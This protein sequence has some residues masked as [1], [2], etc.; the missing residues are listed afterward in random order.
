[1]SKIRIYIEPAGIRDAVE[2]KER[3]VIH[4][5]RDVLRLKKDAL[6]YVFDGKG[7]EYLYRIKDRGK[8][9]ILIKKEKEE[10]REQ[11]PQ[12]RVVL[13]FPLLK[14]EKVDF[15]LQKATE[16]GVCNFCPFI[17]ERSAKNKPSFS[18]LQRWYKI[19]L[20]SVRQSDRLWLPQLNS[21][22]DFKDVIKS[23]YKVK[24]VATIKGEKISNFLHKKWKE[25]FVLVGPEGDFSAREYAALRD[26]GFRFLKLSDNILRTETAAVFSI[27]LVNYYLNES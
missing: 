21:I 4:K 9:Y 23:K 15:I 20:E 5:L 18:K 10:R 13:G 14:E 6:I 25:V 16:L 7:R 1:M 19:V 11:S 22:L 17:C 27:G 26:N 2:I 24:F 3:E 12:N 8:D